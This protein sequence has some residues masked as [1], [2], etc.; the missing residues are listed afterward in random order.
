MAE[1]PGVLIV[2]D[3]R[4]IVDVLRSNL[5]ARG[6]RVVVST[7]GSDV[8]RLLDQ[9]APDVVLLDL[10]L[11]GRDGFDLC[12][13]VRDRSDVGIIV[14]SARRGETDKVRALNLGADD[15]LTKPFGIE[16]LLARINAMLRRARPA[17]PRLVAPQVRVGDVR[18][19]FDAQLVT[20]GGKRVHLT[21]T[22][23]A[24]LREL[25]MHPGRLLTHAELLRR[26]WGPGYETQTEY[27]R[28]YVGRLR[29]K[30]EG[31]DG[32]ELIVTEPRAG[33]RFTT[34]R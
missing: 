3:D 2:E 25:A 31:P 4:I 9:A 21:R 16:E 17:E 1:E 7:D 14:L 23:Y 22:E 20:K 27:T 5:T 24:L 32:A 28:V 33:Y 12:W 30:L 29:A 8:L 6:Y 26:V 18:I 15:Y 10:M 11:P 34:D 13:A 19:D